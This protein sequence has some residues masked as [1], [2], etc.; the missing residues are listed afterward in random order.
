MANY[1]L[2]HGGC[3]G[4]WVWKRVARSL[5]EEGHDVHTP[6][7]TGLGERSHLLNATINLSTNIQDIVNVIKFEELN[8]VI[9]CGHAYAGMI[10]SGVAD[11][12]S[13]RIAALVYLDA[14]VPEDGDSIF[15][16]LP[17]SMQLSII[18]NAA[19]Y[20]GY[21]CPPIPAE[22]LQVNDWDRA[23]VGRLS[24]PH[25]LATM[26][27]G[28]RLHGNHRKVKQRIFALASAWAPSPFRR[29]YEKLLEDPAWIIRT[30]HCGH[31]AM[32]DEP[33]EVVNI[34]R[35]VAEITLNT[36]DAAQGDKR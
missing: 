33:E 32:L 18:K 22:A 6:T 11:L 15:T 14:W 9:L 3:R 19:R 10:I 17:E 20:G 28:I 5:R 12:I 8:D 29:F 31:D 26:T 23:W 1:C 21:C 35:E 2:V 34:L 36:F 7:M 27:E 16:L 4:G 13:E 25:P 30:I 24:T